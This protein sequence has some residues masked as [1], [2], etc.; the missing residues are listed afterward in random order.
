MLRYT[1]VV[2]AGCCYSAAQGARPAT[3]VASTCLLVVP[4]DLSPSISAATADPMTLRIDR[5]IVL[6]TYT[7]FAGHDI[8]TTSTA[9]PQPPAPSTPP[10]H[11]DTLSQ[12][13]PTSTP[14]QQPT[15]TAPP[16]APHTAI[17]SA[18]TTPPSPPDQS[19]SHSPHSGRVWDRI[20][21]LVGVQG[22]GYLAAIIE[23]CPDLQSQQRDVAMLKAARVLAYAVQGPAEIDGPMAAVPFLSAALK[24]AITTLPVEH[25]AVLILNLHLAEMLLRAGQYEQAAVK[26]RWLCSRC[27]RLP[28]GYRNGAAVRLSL[29][30]C[31]KRLGRH[32]EAVSYAHE[33]YCTSEREL[34]GEDEMTIAAL[35]TTLK[36]HFQANCLPPATLAP[37]IQLY[38]ARLKRTGSQDT[39]DEKY[40]YMFHLD[41]LQTC[42]NDLEDFEGAEKATREWLQLSKKWFGPG[43]NVYY[44]VSANITLHVYT[45]TVPEAPVQVVQQAPVQVVHTA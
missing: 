9:A 38:L 7:S 30:R 45:F 18:P 33:A 15:P 31:L 11:A 14:S 20:K 2:D 6:C 23:V 35:D 21:H 22:M 41:K 44:Q 10:T 8:Q 36:C 28:D 1:Y 27:V 42:L 3:L 16:P 39:Q 5:G 4:R 29:A 13:P 34:G 17:S 40:E 24:E 12:P 26:F 19:E 32:T 37:L 25:V 43:H